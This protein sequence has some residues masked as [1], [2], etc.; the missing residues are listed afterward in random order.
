LRSRV[1]TS[2]SPAT[3]VATLRSRPS[4]RTSLQLSQGASGH[5]RYYGQKARAVRK[6][7]R[8]TPSSQTSQCSSRHLRY[9]R[10][11]ARAVSRAAPHALSS[12]TSPHAWQP[13]AVQGCSI[14]G[15]PSHPPPRTSKGSSGHLRYYRHKALALSKA[16]LLKSSSSNLLPNQCK[17]KGTICRH[18]YRNELKSIPGVVRRQNINNPRTPRSPHLPLYS[19][20]PTPKKYVCMYV[21]M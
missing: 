6:A 14:E 3:H 9:D 1:R 4:A 15:S 20:P 10:Q 18:R 17:D 19:P 16:P 12:P 2:H 21:H 8:L 7:T 13:A 11:K 5:H